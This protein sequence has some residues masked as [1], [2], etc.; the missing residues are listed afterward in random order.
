MIQALVKTW[1]NHNLH[2]WLER[3]RTAQPPRGT[4]G[5]PSEAP[6]SKRTNRRNEGPGPGSSTPNRPSWNKHAV[7]GQKNGQAKCMTQKGSND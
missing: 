1:S 7:H 3:R 4:T 6:A 5:R 2:S